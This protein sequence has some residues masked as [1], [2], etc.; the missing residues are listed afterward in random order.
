MTW[1]TVVNLKN[2]IATYFISTLCLFGNRGMAIW[3]MQTKVNLGKS[4]KQIRR[5]LF[6]REKGGV[7]RGC[8]K[9]KSIG[10]EW[11]F[12]MVMAS[13]WLSVADCH[14]LDCCWVRREFFFLLLGYVKVSFFSLERRY[15]S[16]CWSLPKG[17]SGSA[18]E[19][20]LQGFQ[21]QFKWDICFTFPPLHQHCWSRV[22][23]S[24]FGGFVPQCQ[25]GPFRIVIF[26]VKGKVHRL[27]TAEAIFE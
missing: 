15:I 26:Y 2:K 19:F 9:S 6:Y 20:L 14:W 8:L 12:R 4:R 3:E 27:E 13:H 24:A 7:E 5:T 23:F 18:W 17:V 11:E 21:T 25:E 16:S 10:E 22:R 1:C